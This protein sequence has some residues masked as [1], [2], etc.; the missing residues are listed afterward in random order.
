MKALVEHMAKALVDSPDDVSVTEKD[1]EAAGGESSHVLELKVAPEDLAK[2]V[3]DSHA[4]VTMQ[5]QMHKTIWGT[6]K[7]GV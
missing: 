3:L 2:W 7:R 4:P 5:M 6:E 1:V